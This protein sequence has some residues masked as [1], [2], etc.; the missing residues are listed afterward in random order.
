MAAAPTRAM[1]SARRLAGRGSDGDSSGSTGAGGVCSV[2]GDAGV[3]TGSPR[4]GRPVGRWRVRP[5]CVRS[6]GAR[7]PTTPPVVDRELIRREQAHAERGSRRRGAP[8]HGSSAPLGA[9]PRNAL[10]GRRCAA[11]RSSGHEACAGLG[12]SEQIWPIPEPRAPVDSE[13]VGRGSRQGRNGGRPV[14]EDLFTGCAEQVAVSPELVR[15]LL[16]DH[17]PTPEGWC[18]EHGAHPERHP[19]SI[20]RL[21]EMASEFVTERALSRA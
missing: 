10:V 4:V 1:T 12:R 17:V 19:C 6:A 3:L 11:W 20:R 13:G 9:G 2:R 18:R 5:P 7:A 16:L 15:R 21:A 8:S 14:T